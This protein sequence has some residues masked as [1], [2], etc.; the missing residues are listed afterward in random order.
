MSPPSSSVRW[1]KNEHEQQIEFQA[2]T[3]KLVG[4]SL[5][6]HYE[7]HNERWTMEQK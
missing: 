5:G 3:K 1:Q 7:D 2:R 6:I 4:V